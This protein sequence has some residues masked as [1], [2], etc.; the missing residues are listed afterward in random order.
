MML[1]THIFAPYSLA[2]SS[3]AAAEVGI[4]YESWQLAAARAARKGMEIDFLACTFAED[5]SAVP[6]FARASSPLRHYALDTRTG[7]H[8][9]TVGEVWEKAFAEGNGSFVVFTNV[10]IGL[11]PDFYLK[12]HAL[13]SKFEKEHA[14]QGLTSPTTVLEFTRVQSVALRPGEAIPSLDA[15]LAAPAGRHPGHDCFVV[16]RARI[17]EQLRTGGLVLGMPPWGT[18]YHLALERDEHLNFHFVQGTSTDRY[19]FHTG[20][21]A[22]KESWSKCAR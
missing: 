6:G 12:V 15:V 22:N 21:D 17:P 8:L 1:F 13:L 20:V 18:M 9:P 3:L 2:A 7:S 4:V 16:P 14:M 19:T 11:Q 5:Q 10:D